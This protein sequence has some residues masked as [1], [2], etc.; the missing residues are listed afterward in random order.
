MFLFW[1]I[2]N[3]DNNR[4]KAPIY[5]SLSFDSYPHFAI[6]TCL[7][8]SNF[9][10]TEVFFKHLFL[11]IWLRQ[12]L[13]ATQKLLIGAS[14]VALVVK[15]LP[16]RAGDVKDMGQFLG[17]EDPLVEGIAIH[18]SILAWR[19]PWTEEPGGLQSRESQI[20]MTEAT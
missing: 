15:N 4:E 2:P 1:K 16:A 10:F 8:L 11:F 9:Y 17:P 3:I 13:V 6:L 5:F 12:V 7:S 14:P 20:D 19:I 18:S